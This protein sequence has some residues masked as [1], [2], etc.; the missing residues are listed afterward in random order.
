MS[1]FSSFLSEGTSSILESFNMASNP[2]NRDSVIA[3]RLNFLHGAI[4][5]MKK[6]VGNLGE[7]WVAESAQ[8]ASSSAPAAPKQVYLSATKNLHE[9]TTKCTLLEGLFLCFSL[10]NA[11]FSS[12]AILTPLFH[13]NAV[14]LNSHYDFQGC[15]DP[16]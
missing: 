6:M 2:S 16:G 7:E 10:Q 5:V 4:Q 14:E 12:Y 3:E 1:G 15:Q 9:V 13:V 11:S 8:A